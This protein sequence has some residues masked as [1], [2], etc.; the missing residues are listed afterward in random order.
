MKQIPSLPKPIPTPYD[1]WQKLDPT[2]AELEAAHQVCTSDRA[3]I[4]SIRETGD[5]T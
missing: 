3:C 4:R 5:D 2:L 1:P